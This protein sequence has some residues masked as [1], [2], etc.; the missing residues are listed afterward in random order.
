MPYI[1]FDVD[2]P[3]TLLFQPS[4]LSVVGCARVLVTLWLFIM[5]IA[6]EIP[7]SQMSLIK[8]VGLPRGTQGSPGGSN[9]NFKK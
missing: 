7:A 4:C 6:P 3:K 1:Y 5:L 9:S 8:V 2:F